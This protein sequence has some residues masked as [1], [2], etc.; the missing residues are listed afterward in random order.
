M[1]EELRA[2]EVECEALRQQAAVAF[3]DA[4]RVVEADKRELLRL[5]A[6]VQRLEEEKLGDMKV[7]I[8]FPQVLHVKFTQ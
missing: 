4:A 5:Q 7:L 6:E 2:K 1:Q 3:A 8:C